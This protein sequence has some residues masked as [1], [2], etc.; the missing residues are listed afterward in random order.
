MRFELVSIDKTHILSVFTRFLRGII[1]FYLVLWVFYGCRGSWIS[2]LLA[3]IESIWLDKNIFFDLLSFTGFLYFF[4]ISPLFLS[5]RFVFPFYS[6]LII[7]ATFFFHSFF[8]FVFFFLGFFLGL[9]RARLLFFFSRLRFLLV[10]T[11]FTGF[12][13]VLPSFTEFYW[14]FT[15]SYLVLP[16][17]T[18]FYRV[19]MDFIF[20]FT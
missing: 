12:Y 9:R 16:S 15:E 7:F 8:L 13:R 5:V 11:S 17:F 10:E 3:V 18:G 19:F 14:V 6:S 4:V 20:F 1:K 2:F